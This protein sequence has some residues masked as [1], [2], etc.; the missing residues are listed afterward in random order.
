VTEDAG[1]SVTDDARRAA[2]AALPD[3]IAFLGLGLIG[4][5]IALALRAAGAGSTLVAWTPEGRG[6]VAGVKRGVVDIATGSA[7]A[8]IDGAGLIV[9]AGPPLAVLASLSDLAGPLRGRLPAAA[10]ITD[11]A[12]TKALIIENASSYALPFVGGHP[13]AGRER[14][15]VEAADPGLFFD[16]PW[17][18]VPGASARAADV[19]RVEALATATGA[20]PIRLAADEHDAAVAAISH[21]PLVLAAALAESVASRAESWPLARSLAATGWSD[22]T[23]L[24]KGDPEMGAGILSTNALAV[25]ERLRDLRAVLDAWIEQLDSGQ[26]GGDAGVLWGRLQAAREALDVERPA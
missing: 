8:A 22:M 12:S 4:G 3:R 14:S 9:L 13:M 23:R 5:S 15:G 26:G 1:R 20:R 16:R 2:A 6:P 21:V 24:A 19:E 7:E 18:V 25:R 11:V 17:V 10:T